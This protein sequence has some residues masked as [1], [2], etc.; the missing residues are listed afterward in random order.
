MKPDRERGYSNREVCTGP[1]WRKKRQ[2]GPE[3]FPAQ[4]DEWLP[5]FRSNLSRGGL[6][7]Q[8]GVAATYNPRMGVKNPS[9]SMGSEGQS[10][11]AG[12]EK[13][14]E[15]CTEKKKKI[16]RNPAKTTGPHLMKECV[17][18]LS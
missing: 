11:G 13:L 4:E 5:G 8:V 16:K 15:D 7:N 17:K 3:N 10:D 9:T 18:P 1:P 14:G 6:P 12:G 2:T